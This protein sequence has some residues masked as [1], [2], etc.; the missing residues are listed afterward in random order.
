VPMLF[1][2]PR[3]VIVHGEGM[4]LGFL[5]YAVRTTGESTTIVTDLRTL[6]RAIG[7]SAT[8]DSI[9]TM[10]Q[11][12]TGSVRRPRFYAVMLGIFAGIAAVLAAVAIYGLLAFSVTQRTQEIGVRMTLGAQPGEVVRLVMRHGVLLTGIGIAAGVAGAVG[13]TRFLAGMLFGLTPLDPLTYVSVALFFTTVAMAA[14]YLPA[15]RA[16]K[17]DPVIALRY[18]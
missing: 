17:V 1:V 18:E 15:R 16:T 3:Q 8:L 13:L 6:T 11:L 7:P 14:A 9:A 10:E 12:M 2:D 4:A 5:C